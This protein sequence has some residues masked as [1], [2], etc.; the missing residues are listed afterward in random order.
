VPTFSI[1]QADAAAEFFEEEAV[2]G[3]V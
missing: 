3:L 1:G 2:L